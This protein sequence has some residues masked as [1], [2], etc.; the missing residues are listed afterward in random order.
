LDVVEPTGEDKIQSSN[1]HGR[2]EDVDMESLAV[3][4]R[5]F[6]FM[7]K[8]SSKVISAE[9]F[10]GMRYVMYCHSCISMNESV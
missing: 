8:D 4:D 9:L 2:V 7:M 5:M 3:N 1:L 6:V 10:M